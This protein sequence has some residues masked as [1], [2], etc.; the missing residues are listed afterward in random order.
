MKILVLFLSFLLSYS[1]SLSQVPIFDGLPPEINTGVISSGAGVTIIDGDPFITFRLQ[2]AISF[3]KW[4]IGLDV[5]LD[6]DIKNGGIRKENYDEVNDFLSMLRFVQYGEKLPSE[7]FYARLGQLNAT[8]VGNG[9]I[10]YFYNNS[11]TFDN[12]RL[13][14]NTQINFEYGGIDLLYGNFADPGLVGGRLHLYPFSIIKA[15]DIPIIKDMQIGTTYIQDLEPTSTY[16]TGFLDSSTN[17]M[18]V[19]QSV[20]KVSVSGFDVTFPLISSELFSLKTYY[21]FASISGFGSGNALGIS[22][23]I[24]IFDLVR[25]DVR[26]ERRI[27]GEGYTTSYFNALYEIQRINIDPTTNAIQSKIHS[28]SQQKADNGIFGDLMLNFSDIVR[29]YGSYQE[30]DNTPQSGLLRL[31]VNILPSSQ[32][33]FV[34][35][36]L[37]KV[38]ISSFLDEVFEAND[39]TFLYAEGGI[40]MGGNLQFSLLYQKTF[41]AIRS[42]D[43]SIIGYSPQER[44]EPR[45]NLVYPF[46]F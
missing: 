38:N 15:V 25:A 33:F 2:P 17:Q 34:R 4:T 23:S 9:S 36:G 46:T 39:R 29:I 43:N 12:R 41:Q 27:N 30:L 35:G 31:A 32:Q 20:P 37:D 11:P 16:R 3:D 6:Y 22:S 26:L 42:E 40:R 19:T 18:V 24:K 14:I 5:N 8:S 21:D 10:M 45:I 7:P 13:G 44:I 28:V 1:Y